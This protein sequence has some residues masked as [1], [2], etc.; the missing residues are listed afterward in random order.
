MAGELNQVEPMLS[1]QYLAEKQH[2]IKDR[3]RVCN[4]WTCSSKAKETSWLDMDRFCADLLK[5][6]AH[7]APSLEHST[8]LFAVASRFFVHCKHRCF[9]CF[10]ICNL[11]ALTKP[12]GVL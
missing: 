2:T 8:L 1:E 7:S 6:H 4:N 11:S 12:L 5:K 10:L 9:C 3:K